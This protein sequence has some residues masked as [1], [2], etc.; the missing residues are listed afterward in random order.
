[1]NDASHGRLFRGLSLAQTGAARA[2]KVQCLHEP[3][4][5]QNICAGQVG[6]EETPMGLRLSGS[7]Q[8]KPVPGAA[9]LAEQGI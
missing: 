2:V 9:F 6:A 5:S 7:H 8:I 3:Q 4:D 1:M